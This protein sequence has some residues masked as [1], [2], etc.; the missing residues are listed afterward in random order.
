MSMDK[1]TLENLVN[2]NLSQ[3]QIARELKVSQ[4]TI[5]Y[6]LKKF[7]LR[8]QQNSNFGKRS[9]DK[10]GNPCKICSNETIGLRLL[11][12]SCR[13]KVARHKGKQKAVDLLG[14]K[15]M[16]CGWKGNIVA[17]QFHHKDPSTKL[18]EIGNCANKAWKT[19]VEEVLKCELLCANCHIIEHS[20]RSDNFIKF[21]NGALAEMD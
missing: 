11:C 3:R 13:T 21:I 20:N 6:W 14:N 7:N 4:S 12:S 16:R 2:K 9:N 1:H 17:F 15:C 10:I 19:I 8:T 5:K 18:F